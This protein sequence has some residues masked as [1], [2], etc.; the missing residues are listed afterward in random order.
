MKTSV[1]VTLVVLGLAAVI[2]VTCV[3]S[4]ISAYNQGNDAET[5]LKAKESNLQNILASYTTRVS[6]MAQVPDKYK[7]DLLQ[8]IQQNFQG[9]YGKSGNK[10]VVSFIREQNLAL[11]PKLYRN[12]METMEAGRDEFKQAQSDLIDRKRSYERAL[13]SFWTGYWLHKAGYPKMDL[14]QIKPV[15]NRHTQKAFETHMD[16][17]IKLK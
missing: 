2:G 17:G 7:S 11:D 4:Y 16:E 12:L 3:S 15:I 14:S 1:L 10:A 6:E 13:G 5:A 9:R 8:V